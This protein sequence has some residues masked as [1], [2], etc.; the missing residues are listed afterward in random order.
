MGDTSELRTQTIIYL[1]HLENTNK[2]YNKSNSFT[3]NVFDP[4]P[5]ICEK[6][7]NSRMCYY[8]NRLSMISAFAVVSIYD[9]PGIRMAPEMDE[10]LRT[11]IRT[12]PHMK[13]AANL[14]SSGS[15]TKV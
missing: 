1:T 11:H 2:S 4:I 9:I 14:R 13:N 6:P 3:Q 7:L 5:H 10:L 12:N 15:K 8:I